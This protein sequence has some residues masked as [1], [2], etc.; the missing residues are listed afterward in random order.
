VGSE[1]GEK[2]AQNIA[3]GVAGL[4]IWP[5]WFAMDFQGAATKEIAALEARNAYL[6]G[7][8]LQTCTA[9]A[10]IEKIAPAAAP[11]VTPVGRT[12]LREVDEPGVILEP[13]RGPVDGSATPRAVA[14]NTPPTP[15]IVEVNAR[16]L[17]SPVEALAVVPPGDPCAKYENTPTESRCK[18]YAAPDGWQYIPF[19]GRIA[20]LDTQLRCAPLKTNL[21]Y[22]EQ[23][24]ARYGPDKVGE[25]RG[26]PLR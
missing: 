24:I 7:R 3:A 1:Q 19:V 4:I 5:L 11:S 25:R 17:A 22:Y 20:D 21:V 26:I 10:Q 18:L 15:R 6:A 13:S 12:G 23:C 14:M 9:V 16:P 2:L 8:A